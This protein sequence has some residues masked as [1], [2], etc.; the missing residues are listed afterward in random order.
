MNRKLKI[1]IV[2]DVAMTLCLLLLMPYSLLGEAAHEWIGVTMFVLFVGHHILNRKWIAALAKGKYSP[3]RI[4]QTVVVAAMFLCMAGSMVSGVI[5]SNH[6]FKFVKIAGISMEAR[7][8][9]M[10]CAY[11]GF[12]VMSLHL[13]MHWNMVAGI[14]GRL[15]HKPSAIRGWAARCIAGLIACYGIYVF[16]K[17]QIGDYLFMRMHFAFYDYTETVIFFILDYLAVMILVAIVGYYL[18]KILK[19]K[20]MTNNQKV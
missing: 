2:M 17:R 7:Q 10:F 4:W 14:I 5:L 9:H 11:W 19:K 15:Y 20:D 8:V 12:V 16:G 13:G 18:G 1:R 3:Y 6:V